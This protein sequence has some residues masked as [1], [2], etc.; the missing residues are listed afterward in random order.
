MKSFVFGKLKFF[1]FFVPT[2]ES[3][4]DLNIR[5]FLSFFF[6]SRFLFQQ[7]K[8]ERNLTFGYAFFLLFSRQLRIVVSFL[9]RCVPV[10]F[11]FFCSTI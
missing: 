9:F 8:V 7:L 5:V 4:K 2:I 11:N 3:N 6:F 10:C 1:S